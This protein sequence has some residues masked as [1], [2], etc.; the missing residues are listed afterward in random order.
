MQRNQMQR[1]V[2]LQLQKLLQSQQLQHP[3]LLLHQSIPKFIKT[4]KTAGFKHRTVSKMPY[5]H[6]GLYY[7]LSPIH[8]HSVWETTIWSVLSKYP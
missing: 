5:Q 1:L 4:V 2:P 7:R 6:L 8:K 3:R